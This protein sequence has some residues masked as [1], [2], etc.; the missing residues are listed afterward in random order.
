MKGLGVRDR[1]IS[2]IIMFSVF[3][4][5]Y[6]LLSGCAPKELKEVKEDIELPGL[7][8]IP[9]YYEDSSAFDTQG[10]LKKTQE[11]EKRR[12]KIAD[13]GVQMPDPWVPP[14]PPASLP[15]ALSGFPKDKYGYPDWTAAVKAG[16]LK[17]QDSIAKEEKKEETLFDK[18]ILFEINDRLMANVLFPHKIH[19]FWFSCKVCHPSIFIDKKGANQFTMY[20]IW[21]GQYCGRCHGKVAFMPKGFENCRRCHSVKKKTMGPK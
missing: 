13:L 12:F 8:T 4:L 9:F 7:S 19:N 6:S 14:S 21:N 16:I 2:E 18:D 1:I 5:L 17:P 20:D 11:E 15:P 3:C 10:A